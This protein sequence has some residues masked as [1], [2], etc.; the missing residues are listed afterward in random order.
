MGRSIW[1]SP[2]LSPAPGSSGAGSFLPFPKKKNETPQTGWPAA[3]RSYERDR[4][5]SHG[6]LW[7]S[8]KESVPV[9]TK[10][11]GSLYECVRFQ[12]ER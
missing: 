2:R 11:C 7:G 12:P 5:L 10:N 1:H 4:V 8:N 6:S 3:Y 9:L